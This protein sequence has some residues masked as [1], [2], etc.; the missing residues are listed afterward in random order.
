MQTVPWD[1]FVRSNGLEE[2]KVY[3]YYLGSTPDEITEEVYEKLLSNLFADAAAVGALTLPSPYRPEDFELSFPA[4][5]VA[6]EIR[7]KGDPERKGTFDYVNYYLWPDKVMSSEEVR[8]NLL[9]M[10][11]GLLALF[12]A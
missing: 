5:S 9:L 2:V 8:H 11:K 7:L 12:S 3:H 4:T 10:A 1:E 6:A